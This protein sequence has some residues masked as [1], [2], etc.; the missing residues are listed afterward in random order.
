[1]NARRVP[2]RLSYRRLFPGREVACAKALV[3]EWCGEGKRF[4]PDEFD[5]LLQQ[6]LTHWWQVRH[7]YDATREASILSYM[8][9]VVGRKLVDLGRERD[10]EKR[11]V[12]SEALSLDAPVGEDEDSETFG[13]LQEAPAGPDCGLSHDLTT[14]VNGLTGRQQ[15]ICEL[16]SQGVSVTAISEALGTSRSTIHDEIQRI[17]RHFTDRGL[18]DYL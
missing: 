16:W 9:A 13:D 11:R 2:S 6:V 18:A 1:M 4:E 14:A 12:L 17:R 8:R 15:R 3:R 7:R 10:A 5:D